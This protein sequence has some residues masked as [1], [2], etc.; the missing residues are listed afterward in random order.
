MGVLNSSLWNGAT[1]EM[2]AGK[3]DPDEIL[4]RLIRG[5][6]TI[7]LFMAVPTIY[8]NLAKHLLHGSHEFDDLEEV[9]ENLSKLRLMVS[10]SAALPVTQMDEWLQLSGQTL[11]ERFGMT[12]ILMALSNPYRPIDQ[13]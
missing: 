11:L 3:F 6:D 9:K 10:G 2:V 1:C 13:R 12:E 5:E 8:N 7:S 4:R